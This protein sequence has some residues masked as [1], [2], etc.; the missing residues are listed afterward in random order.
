MKNRK[1]LHLVLILLCL[2]A[3]LGYRAL[4]RLNTDTTAPVISIGTEALQ[5]SVQDPETQLLQGV[6][7]RDE[8]DG[9]VSASLVV[10]SVQL[11]AADGLVSVRYAAFDKAGNVAKSERQVQY[12]DYES[13]RFSLSEPLV[14]AQNSSFDVF[15]IV[16]VQDVLDGDIT[17]RLRATSLDE[18][19]IT[20]VGV[21]DVEFRVTNSLG[22]TVKLVLPVEVYASGAYQ[23]NLLLTDYLIYLPT[24][25]FFDEE[26]YLETFTAGAEKTSL[27]GGLPSGFSLKTT[28]NVDTSTPGVYSVAYTVT[29]NKGS[30]TTC[31]GYSK[32][33]VV[34]E[35]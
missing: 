6:S 32:L 16:E 23:A 21:H 10:E 27:L 17:H 9:D 19:S 11:E 5:L 13:P 15:R 4:D 2:M 29:Y 18:T 22:E 30:G 25:T 3:F 24:G 26:S 33:I 31:T 12:T 14:F 28:G 1:W 20:T 7:A 35:G 34:V 8:T